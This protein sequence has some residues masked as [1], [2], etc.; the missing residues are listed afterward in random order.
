MLGDARRSIET[1][2][3]SRLLT[4]SSGESP[5]LQNKIKMTKYGI[6]W[7]RVECFCWLRPCCTPVALLDFGEIVDIERLG[8]ER[9]D[10]EE[11]GIPGV[12]RGCKCM[13]KNSRH[14]CSMLYCFI[15]GNTKES[16]AIQ[17]CLLFFGWSFLMRSDL[18]GPAWLGNLMNFSRPLTSGGHLCKGSNRSSALQISWWMD[19]AMDSLRHSAPRCEICWRH[20]RNDIVI[21]LSSHPCRANNVKVLIHIQF[22]Y[23]CAAF[24]HKN[25]AVA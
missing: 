1:L 18:I 19:Y 10:P 25:W 3:F 16:S 11:G 17:M 12:F 24:N 23:Q 9:P 21:V 2:C 13:Q 8:D 14:F 20:A 5:G 15:R 4:P 22:H 6:Q 7:N